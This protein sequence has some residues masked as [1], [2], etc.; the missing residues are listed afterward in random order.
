MTLSKLWVQQQ[1]TN[2]NRL[3]CEC[4]HTGPYSS[5]Y[6]YHR[7]FFT[8]KHWHFLDFTHRFYKMFLEI[9]NDLKIQK[10]KLEEEN[11]LLRKR[12]EKLNCRLINSD[13]IYNKNRS[14]TL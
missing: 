3:T 14:N 13:G 10:M 5:Q 1:F 12:I 4:T 7:H 6:A 9:I 2:D 11:K 8:D